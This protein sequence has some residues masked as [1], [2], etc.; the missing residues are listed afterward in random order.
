MILNR[1]HHGSVAETVL[2]LA[3]A[4]LGWLTLQTVMAF[5]YANLYYRGRTRKGY[6]VPI[7][8]PHC[9][10]PGPWEFIYVST[11]IGMTAQVSD[12]NVQS[13]QMRRAM[14]PHSIV[15][16]F[17]NTV[18]IAMAVNAAVSAAT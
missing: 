9:R 8:F 13:T 5:H 12:T 1:K 6:V 11:V 16:F 3:G 14:T 4:P 7:D 2:T 18:L 10:E 15:S 17:F